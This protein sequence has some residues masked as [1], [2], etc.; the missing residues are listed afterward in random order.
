MPHLPTS[1]GYLNL[2]IFS[3]HNIDSSNIYNIKVSS[4]VPKAQPINIYVHS[5]ADR[6]G[7]DNYTFFAQKFLAE[8]VQLAVP[9]TPCVHYC[10]IACSTLPHTLHGVTLSLIYQQRISAVVC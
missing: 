3:S 7:C 10:L 8:E 5:K 2:N 1:K 6:I 9:D 4:E